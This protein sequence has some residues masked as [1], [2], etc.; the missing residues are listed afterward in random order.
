M[1][2]RRGLAGRFQPWRVYYRWN[3]V[4][5]I[6]LL[7][8]PLLLILSGGIQWY[9]EVP[10]YRSTT[11]FEVLGD[12]PLPAMAALLKSGNVLE[13]AVRKLELPRRMGVDIDTAI[14]IVSSNLE[15]TADP[16]ASTISL[17]VTNTNSELAR[18]LAA[19]LPKALEDY[20]NSLAAAALDR[21]IEAA[22][23]AANSM[24]D[25]AVAKREELVQLINLRGPAPAAEISRLDV[26]EAKA[27]WEHADRAVLD[28]R[29]R[30]AAD[31]RK[32]AHPER[33]VVVYTQPMRSYT[34]EPRKA[35]KSL[36]AVFLRAI[37]AGLAVALALPY[38]LELAFPRRRRPPPLRPAPWENEAEVWR[39]ERA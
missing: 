29:A 14:G 2:N 5:R 20:E 16:A 9:L 18:D 30:I 26:D 37:G 19:A 6:G 4:V 17:T 27:G 21:R 22:A 1:K 35:G 7:V 33:V 34:P 15:T 23:I 36:T 39:E 10:R 3:F 38:L 28:E 12:R 31:R 25:Y 11:V 8:V 32:L 13:S 24:E